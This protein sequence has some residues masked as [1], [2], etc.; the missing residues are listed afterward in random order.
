VTHP[1]PL[2]VFFA[3][4]YGVSWVIWAPLW[5]PR[6]GVVGLP[7]LPFHHTY[8]AL[9][10]IAA[11][12]VISTLESGRA[13]PADLL[14]RM[15]LWRGRLLWV[16]TGLLGPFVFL[17]I[18]LLCAQIFAGE[19]L[20]LAGVGA[21]REFPHFSPVELLLFNLATFGFGEET[22]W[23]GFALPRLQARHSAL[24][25][26]MILTLGWAGWHVPLFFYRPGYVAMDSAAIVGWICS[27]CAGGVLLTWLHI[28]SRRSILVV[29]LFAAAVDLVFTSDISSEFVQRATGAAFVIAAVVVIVVAGPRHLCRTASTA[30]KG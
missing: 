25:A 28:Q 13:G 8:G 15:V 4:A 27:L 18:A 17:G 24:V 26:T 10:P 21:S 30:D 6:F 19:A 2:W 11:A 7:V 22:G 14:R 1:R 29:A 3:L 9:G 16:A 5:L 23:R 12:F 20:S